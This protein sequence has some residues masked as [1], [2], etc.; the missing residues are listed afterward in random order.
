MQLSKASFRGVEFGVT[1]A[2]LGTGRRTVTHEFP[3][4]DKPHIE[5]LGRKSRV[6]TVEAYVV[7]DDWQDKRNAL[8]AAL[9]E[10]GPGVLVHPYYGEVTVQ[11]STIKETESYADG[12]MATFSIEFSD[13]GEVTFASSTKDSAT[14]VLTAVDSAQ[15]AAAD[16][17]MAAVNAHEHN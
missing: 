17:Y 10:Y 16:A 13:T 5:D 7:G 1:T 8:L 9:E 15:S 3:G 11:V 4:R 6:F 12:R 14:A 2:E